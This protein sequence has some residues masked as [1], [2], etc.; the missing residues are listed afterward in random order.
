MLATASFGRASPASAAPWKLRAGGTSSDG[1]IRAETG[2]VEGWALRAA[3]VVG[4][5]HRLAALGNDDAFAWRAGA[6]A[7][8]VAVADG[9][10]NVAGSA[11]A[12]LRAAGVAVDA[13]ERAGGDSARIVLEAA[14]TAANDALRGGEGATTLV[15]AVVA[16]DGTATV[17]RVGDSSAFV[18]AGGTWSELFTSS[19]GGGDG[20]VVS[21]TTSALPA[22]SPRLETAVA[23]LSPGSALVLVT[24]GVADPLRDGPGTVAPTLADGLAAPPDVGDLISLVDFSRQGCHDDRTLLGVWRMARAG[25]PTC[26]VEEA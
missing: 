12:A 1:G 26:P 18:L 17:A 19:V 16:A 10:S 2:D 11:A 14:V 3:S 20:G 21:T 25:A 6:S 7:L 22:G 15:V 9:V 4:V 8:M 23:G 13:A 5:R 24:D